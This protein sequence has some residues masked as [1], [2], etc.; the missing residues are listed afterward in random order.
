[1]GRAIASK[2]GDTRK[3]MRDYNGR[4][5]MSLWRSPHGKPDAS[6]PGRDHGDPG[7]PRGDRT[8]LYNLTYILVLSVL[9]VICVADS[10]V[11][12]ALFGPL[13]EEWLRT[14]LALPHGIPSH[15]MLGRVFARPDAAPFAGDFRDWVQAAF[16]LTIGQVIPVDGQSVGSSHDRGRGLGP[17]HLVSAWAQAHRLVLAQTAVDDQ[18]HESTAIPAWLRMLCLKGCP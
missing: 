17:L 12:I 10:F 6:V 5:R 7:E 4:F 14:F 11:A 15:D 1:M 18:S 13:N 2:W 3:W 8:K 16:A 9:A